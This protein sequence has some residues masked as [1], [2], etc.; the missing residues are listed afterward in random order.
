MPLPEK[1]RGTLTEGT[2]K[3]MKKAISKQIILWMSVF[4]SI[5]LTAGPLTMVN[6]ASIRPSGKQVPLSSQT[7]NAA[8]GNPDNAFNPQTDTVKLESSS[9]NVD[10]SGEEIDL[11]AQ[12][13]EDAKAIEQAKK[14]GSEVTV[15]IPSDEEAAELKNGKNY[16]VKLSP[17]A[18][19]AK[20][21]ATTATLVYQGPNW[22]YYSGGGISRA[23][24]FIVNGQRAFCSY[25][26]LATPNSGRNTS[27]TLSVPG[28]NLQ[29]QILKILYYGYE[30]P[31]CTYSSWPF[32]STFRGTGNGGIILTSLRLSQ[33]VTGNYSQTNVNGMSQFINYLNS[34]P[35]PDFNASFSTGTLNG[36]VDANGTIRT[37]EMTVNGGNAAKVHFAVP[38]GTSLVTNGRTYSAGQWLTFT[39]GQK[40]YLVKT[41]RESNGETQSVSA[42]RDSYYAIMWFTRPASW[43]N[44]SQL[45]SNPQGLGFSVKWPKLGRLTLHKTNQAQTNIQGATFHLKATGTNGYDATKTTDS[46]GNLTFTSIPDGTYTLTETYCPPD[47]FT[48]VA[49]YTVTV[50]NGK[51]TIKDN[52]GNAVAVANNDNNNTATIINYDK[53]KFPVIKYEYG[54]TNQ[55][56]EHALFKLTGPNN[57]SQEK[58]TDANGQALFTQLMPGTYTLVE[59]AA[60]QNHYTLLKDQKQWTVVVSKDANQKFS[61]T[62]KDSK[63]NKLGTAYATLSSV[64]SKKQ[65]TKGKA[66]LQSVLDNY[67]NSVKAISANTNAASTQIEVPNRKTHQFKIHKTDTSG[68]NLAGA[69]FNLVAVDNGETYAD[70]QKT[71]SSGYVTFTDLR[72]GTYKLTENYA[73][74]GYHKDKTVYTV[75]VTVSSIKVYNEAGNIVNLNSNGSVNNTEV[76][77]KNRPKAQLKIKKTES[78]T[79]TLL[80]GATF[81]LSKDG[82]NSL[83]TKT[84]QNTGLAVFKNLDDGNYTLRETRAPV[85]HLVLP[86]VINVTV[87]NSIVSVNTNSQSNVTTEKDSEGSV[88]CINIA[89]TKVTPKSGSFGLRKLDKDT[90]KTIAG[91]VWTLYKYNITGTADALA[92]TAPCNLTS[93]NKDT[94]TKAYATMTAD[95]NGQATISGLSKGI[96]LIKETTTPNHY[97]TLLQDTELQANAPFAVYVDNNGNVTV[98]KQC[99]DGTSFDGRFSDQYRLDMADIQSQIPIY[100]YDNKKYPD[101]KIKKR[102]RDSKAVLPGVTFSLTSKT[103]TSNVRTAT[104]DSNGTLTFQNVPAGNYILQET[105]KPSGYQDITEKWYLTVDVK[106]NVIFTE[107]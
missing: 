50:S 42:S 93:L 72:E 7:L 99:P 38:S 32:F 69:K 100:T 89:N 20:L 18:V 74:S 104:T 92:S 56:L 61:Y 106:G 47:Y 85:D 94:T 96:Y 76:T 48:E 70:A 10:T 84:T 35:Q 17:S 4:F 82:T 75:V 52:K 30:G 13:E 107:N 8:T 43:Q 16:P 91:A 67:T 105:R 46:S 79:G 41:D 87:K 12:K 36:Y 49:S 78:G 25:H 5:L 57:Y 26:A 60:S 31:G 51:A 66:K 37:N 77:I 14:D 59:E 64:K 81:I 33:V 19:K 90:G 28:G 40:F 15:G 103:N 97:F 9:Q 29:N 98:Y 3:F 102:D 22:F 83:W 68:H 88:I 54:N 45:K 62:F 73:P 6:A 86:K 1:G 27:V 53:G 65:T 23:G 80:E 21:Q 39:P 11:E 58:Y 101:I 44:M 71:D 24:S 34:K 2:K 55:K 95:A 63:G